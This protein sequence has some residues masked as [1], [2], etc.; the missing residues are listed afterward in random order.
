MTTIPTM[1]ELE[2]M[3]F[4]RWDRQILKGDYIGTLV[5]IF[6]FIEG[7]DAPNVLLRA[8]RKWVAKMTG[9]LN[10]D[11]AMDYLRYLVAWECHETLKHVLFDQK[12][13]GLTVVDS[14][15]EDNVIFVAPMTLSLFGSLM[16][17]LDWLAVADRLILDQMISNAT[18]QSCALS[19]I[20]RLDCI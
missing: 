3:S 10:I 8:N 20:D 17:N 11:R 5:D 4:L 1:K 6:H 14:L 2:T 7:G 15:I 19:D 13:E 16:E 18:D 12:V 9:D